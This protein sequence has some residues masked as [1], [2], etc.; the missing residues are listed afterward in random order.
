MTVRLPTF[1]G[2]EAAVLCPAS[3]TVEP[4]DDASEAAER[5]TAKHAFLEAVCT[6]GWGAA[7][8]SAP[9]DIRGW[10]ED[11]DPER[12][13]ELARSAFAAEVAFVL[14]TAT[15]AAREIG[16][17]IGRA[18]PTLSPTEL[19]GTI[20]L[21]GLDE[22][23]ETAIAL[24]FKNTRR[25][26]TPAARNWQLKAAAVAAARAYRRSRAVV[27]LI[28]LSDEGD[29]WDDVATLEAFDLTLAAAELADLVETWHRQAQAPRYVRG[30][31]CRYCRGFDR[32]PAQRE[33]LTL[34]AREVQANTR[35][36][37]GELGQTFEMALTNGARAEAYALWQA[38]QV[39]TKRMGQR[40]TDHASMRPIDLGGGRL[41]GYA[42]GKEMV[43]D[44]E[45]AHQVLVKMA[46]P[47]IAESAIRS[48]V[49]VSATKGDIDKAIKK[50]PKDARPAVW[51][52]LRDV[53]ALKRGVSPKEY[54]AGEAGEE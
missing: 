13:P 33:L 32:C 49:V 1:S 12:F 47:E 53:G 29:R 16:R 36:E 11:L 52:R 17:G 7:L 25:R 44:A 39:L 9:P 6:R 5:G 37:V 23:G 30:P 27:G 14:D 4:Y 40:I 21:I 48:Q 46:G 34:A 51:K 35:G 28:Y 18:Y 41:Y 19:A 8:D 15:G 31:H 2:I 43:A 24:D 20:D 45:K 42:P 54:E 38:M 3:L 22:D 50:L 10:A 26:L